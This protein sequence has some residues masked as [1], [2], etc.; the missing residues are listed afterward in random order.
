MSPPVLTIRA[1]ACWMSD[2]HLGSRRRNK[3]VLKTLKRFDWDTLERFVM[4]GD[5]RDPMAPHGPR[6]ATTQA[7][8]TKLFHFLAV[9]AAEL[10]AK[11]GEARVFDHAGNHD[12]FDK[13]WPW[14]AQAYPEACAIWQGAIA[15]G[16]VELVDK[17]DLCI[18]TSATGLLLWECH[19]HQVDMF[20][21]VGQSFSHGK[22]SQATFFMPPVLKRGI[23]NMTVHSTYAAIEWMSRLTPWSRHHTAYPWMRKGTLWFKV[24]VRR[25]HHSIVDHA[26]RKG[27]D[28]VICSVGTAVSQRVV[29]ELWRVGRF[30]AQ[31]LYGGAARWPLFGATPCQ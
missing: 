31:Y 5:W 7:Y 15:A 8:A 10:H 12:P 3:H 25:F 27:L 29:L 18:H 2:V 24:L 20:H 22:G 28:G 16:H 30:S 23:K 26:Q 13:L 19:G 9:R 11:Y 1:R 17:D 21:H 4:L 14:F 6:I